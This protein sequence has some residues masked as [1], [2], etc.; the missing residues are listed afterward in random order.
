[1]LL[2]SQRIIALGSWTIQRYL[3]LNDIYTFQQ[4]HVFRCDEPTVGDQAGVIAASFFPGQLYQIL[5]KILYDIRAEQR[6]AAEPGN[7]DIRT[8]KMLQITP[9]KIYHC[10]PGL[11][12]HAA[13]TLLLKAIRAGKIAGKGRTDCQT[14]YASGTRCQKSP[15][16]HMPHLI[17]GDK[18]ASLQEFLNYAGML[19]HLKCGFE[20]A[21]LQR[22]QPRKCCR[23]EVHQRICIFIGYFDQM[24]VL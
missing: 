22:C 2:P 9:G 7:R 11:L 21:L 12:T 3:H 16:T 5:R 17:I 15:R 20:H 13:G 1:M 19:I 24:I 18:E 6:L 10:F 14:Q 4:G 8:R 23:T